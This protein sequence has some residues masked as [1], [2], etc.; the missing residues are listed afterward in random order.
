MSEAKKKKNSYIKLLEDTTHLKSGKEKLPQIRRQGCNY[1]LLPCHF[2][3][4]TS[5]NG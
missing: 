3:C 1:A 2:H 4:V 5:P